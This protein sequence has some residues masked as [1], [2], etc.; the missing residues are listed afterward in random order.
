MTGHNA[1]DITP[2]RHRCS[3][4]ESKDIGPQPSES[5]KELQLEANACLWPT[6]ELL[7]YRHSLIFELNLMLGRASSMI[8]A[9]WNLD[10]PHETAERG[11]DCGCWEAALKHEAPSPD[12]QLDR[13]IKKFWKSMPQHPQPPFGTRSREI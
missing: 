11:V 4:T 1:T 13:E 12:M 6:P 3:R 9:I 7:I 10:R 5:P 2:C 8:D